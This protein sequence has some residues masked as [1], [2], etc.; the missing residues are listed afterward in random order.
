[1]ASAKVNTMK[2]SAPVSEHQALASLQFPMSRL[3]LA[4]P[5][6]INCQ[7]ISPHFEI[8]QFSKKSSHHSILSYCLI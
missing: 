3:A 4:H 7:Q 8:S 6:S 2:S 5:P 1:M